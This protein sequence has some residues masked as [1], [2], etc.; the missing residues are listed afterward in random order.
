M[1]LLLLFCFYGTWP[2][3]CM[4]KFISACGS[5]GL[6]SFD[7]EGGKTSGRNGG[8]KLG[9]NWMCSKSTD[10]PGLPQQ[11]SSF[12]KTVLQELPQPPEM[13]SPHRP[14][15]QICDPEGNKSHENTTMG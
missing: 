4:D 2:K 10:C 7:G 9:E 8:S 14:E 11:V 12:S 6:G 1:D 15:V 3:Q 5:R 13:V